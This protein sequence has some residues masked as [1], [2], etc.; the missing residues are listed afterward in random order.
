M[1]RIVLLV[2]LICVIVVIVNI[3]I[4]INT[5]FR[6]KEIDDYLGDIDEKLIN[7]NLKEKNKDV[8]HTKL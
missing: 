7:K 3:I 6:A 8:K 5:I 1:A 4:I 2:L